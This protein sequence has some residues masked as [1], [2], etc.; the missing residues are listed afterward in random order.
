MGYVQESTQK[1][2]K[3]EFSADMKTFEISELKNYKPNINETLYRY[4]LPDHL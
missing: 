1:Q 2:L 3:I 4:V